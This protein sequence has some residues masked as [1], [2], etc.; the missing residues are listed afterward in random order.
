MRRRY[1]TVRGLPKEVCPESKVTDAL[2]SDRSLKLHPIFLGFDETQIMFEH[3]AYGA[4]LTEIVT[5]LVKRGPAVGIMVWLATQR[6]DAKSIPTGISANAVLRLCLKVMG[7]VEN[8]MVLGTSAYKNG[9]RATMFS[10]KDL[11][12]AILVGEGEDPTIVRGAY[13]DSP[14]AAT[15][16]ARARAVRAAEGRLSGMAAGEAQP[17][18]DTGS[19]VNHLLAV[20]P[21][22]DPDWPAGKVWCDELAVRLAASQPGL[23]GGWT[24]EQ[25]T[26]AVRPHGIRTVQVKR[27]LDG[28]QV[29]KRGLT[30][31][32]LTDALG[33]TEPPAPPSPSGLPIGPGELPIG[34]SG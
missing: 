13:V 24:G 25:V 11:G 31:S 29:N 28:R 7:Q 14:T 27:P 30:R 21:E 19:V 23:Y 12:I 26:S 10:R 9:V 2:A 16:A 8:D 20:W 18:A 34:P 15:I 3:P 17:D 32:H 6:P 5:D 33:Q 4:E 22:A 1:R